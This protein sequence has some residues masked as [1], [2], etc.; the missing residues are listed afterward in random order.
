MLSVVIPTYGKAVILGR[1]LESLFLQEGVRDDLEIIVVDDGSP[2]E[3]ER[4]VGLTARKATV[5]VHYV[6]QA[7]RGVSAARNLGVRRAKGEWILLLCDDIVCTPRVVAEH[8][9]WHDRFRGPKSVVCGPVMWPRDLPVDR[10]MTWLDNGGP[11]FQYYKLKGQTEITWRN[12]YAC[13]VSLST[14]SLLENPFDE[15]IKY[16]FED[17]ELGLRLSEHGH[18]FYFNESALGYHYHTR[19]LRAFRKRQTMTGA[20][21]Y[22]A[23]RNNPR[24]RLHV[25][26]PSV[27]RCR[28][29]KTLLRGSCLPLLKLTGQWRMVEKY[30]KVEL[31]IALRKGYRAAERADGRKHRG[32]LAPVK[33]APGG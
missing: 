4:I 1:V 5:P 9:L 18:R 27:S 24:M 8:R 16:G 3:T 6:S 22:Y 7:N 28:R 11:Q 2:D 23:R 21:L 13:N 25:G 17:T 31:D 26:L 29:V 10:F 32:S 14:E 19:D 20:S 30:W 12:F 15:E 33:A